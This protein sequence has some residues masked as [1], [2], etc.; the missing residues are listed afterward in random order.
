MIVAHAT[1]TVFNM[2]F[3]ARTTDAHHLAIC[4]D[5]EQ[6]KPCSSCSICQR[7]AHWPVMQRIQLQTLVLQVLDGKLE[8]CHLI[9]ANHERAFIHDHDGVRPK[10]FLHCSAACVVRWLC[11]VK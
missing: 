10:T 6:L 11:T 7:E 2:W 4:R 9:L 8:I 1:D 3:G 5:P